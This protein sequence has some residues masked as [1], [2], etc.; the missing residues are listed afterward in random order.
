MSGHDARQPERLTTSMRLVRSTRRSVDELRILLGGLS[1]DDTVQLLLTE[2]LAAQYA[3][4]GIK[5]DPAVM[6]RDL[7]RVIAGT[8]GADLSDGELA[9]FD[10]I[11]TALDRIVQ[12]RDREQEQEQEPG[13]RDDK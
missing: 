7:L 5:R 6:A 8:W 13:D 3:R 1:R 11:F 4:L 2:G 9:A 10:V 12:I